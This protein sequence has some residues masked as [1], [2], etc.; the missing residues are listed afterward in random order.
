[1]GDIDPRQHSAEHILTAVFGQLFHG[2]IIDSRF[3]GPKVRCDFELDGEI[4]LEENIEKAEKRA[5]SIISE[6]REVAFEE[7]SSEEAK[8]LCSLHRLPAGIEKVRIVR[9]GNDVI[10]PC[11]GQHVKNT[12]E[13]G[14]LKIRT[15]N[16]ISPG[17]LR[18][19]FGLEE[20]TL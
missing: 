19:T 5:N 9:I 10:T 20:F 2:K 7:V 8:R 13:I 11:R 18:L 15:S 16:F 12:K 1:M 3:K 6:G 17:I 4:P 14:V